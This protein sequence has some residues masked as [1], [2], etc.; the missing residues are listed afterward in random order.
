VTARLGKRALAEAIGTYFLVLVGPGAAMVDAYSDG[1]VTHPGVALSF[2]F[3]VLAMIYALGHI[4]GAHIN[5]AVTIA[6]WSAGRFP[7]RDIVPYVAAQYA[8]RRPAHPSQEEARLE[9]SAKEHLNRLSPASRDRVAEAVQPSG[10]D[11]MASALGHL[12]TVQTFTRTI[13][14]GMEGPVGP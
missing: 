7:A 13:R 1:A 5:P 4:S 2:A 6:F 12:Q 11:R 14:E 8:P 3:V 10:S 9:R